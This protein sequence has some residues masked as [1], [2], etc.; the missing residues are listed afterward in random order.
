[1]NL[2]RERLNLPSIRYF[3]FGLLLLIFAAVLQHYFSYL[4][5]PER[6]HKEVERTLHEKE[7]FLSNVLET[8][9]QNP[10]FFYQDQK[11]ILNGE[12]LSS[13]LPDKGL[14]V[15]VYQKD[16]LVY[17]STNSIVLPTDQAMLKKSSPGIEK[18][19]NGY[20]AIIQ[21]ADSITKY[22]GLILIKNEYTIENE[23]IKSNFQ[24]DFP[25]PAGTEIVFDSNPG[26]IKDVKADYLFTLKL[27]EKIPP[28]NLQLIVLLILYIT[29]F[30]FFIIA[31]YRFFLG[32]SWNHQIKWLF[33]VIFIMTVILLRYLQVQF[34]FPQLLYDSALFGP[35]C[36]S[37]SFIL[38]SAGDFLINALILLVISYLLYLHFPCSFDLSKRSTILKS[39]FILVVFLVLLVG[40]GFC[41][42]VIRVLVIN[43]SIP[44]TLQKISVLNSYSLV[45]F[46]IIA[47]VFLSYLLI[48]VRLLPYF[49]ILPFLKGHHQRNV[50]FSFKVNGRSVV[51]FLFLMSA[52]A[53]LVL[54][55]YNDVVEMEKRKLLA[56]KLSTNQDPMAEMLFTM[57]EDELVKEPLFNTAESYDTRHD[58]VIS[59]DSLT[60]FVLKKYFRES[61]NNY[62][63]QITVCQQSKLL[64]IQPRNELVNCETYFKD[65]I[66]DFGKPT[67]S[68][69]LYY[70]DYGYGFRNYLAVM[71]FGIRESAQ[72]NGKKVYI[73]ISSKLSF[74]DLGYPEL[75]IDKNH[76]PV[77]D[78]ADYSY[79]F[80]RDGRLI[81]RVGSNQ[82]SL[83]LDHTLTHQDA[84]IHY[85]T[86]LGL[87]CLCYPIDRNNVLIISKKAETL[88]D[89]IAP[90]AYLFFVFGIFTFLF[91]L[92]VRRPF[93]LY[94]VRLKF[95]DRLQ[96]SMIGMLITSLIIVGFLVVYY[97]TQLNREKN[98]QS[99]SE[100]AHSML[101]E[102]Q[103]K[104]GAEE[105]LGNTG[106]DDLNELLVKFSNVFFC[107]VNLYNPG[108][109]LI[110]SSRPQVF[111]EGLISNLINNNAYAN[112]R[113]AHSSLY[114]HNETIGT[115]HYSSAYIPF[116]NDRSKLLAY[117]NLP[118]F[119]KQEEL[120]REIS[121]FLM[122]FI[123]VYVFLI[124]IGFFIAILVSN[125]IT[126][127]L[128]LLTQ[129]FVKLTL[130]SSNEKLEWHGN[131]EVGKLVQEYN[132]K[133]DELARSAEMLAQ[134]ERETAW[135]EM[136]RQIAHEIKNP[137][138]P[139]KLSV[140]YLQ[141]SW[142][143]KA[144]NWD[145]RIKRFT[146]T[147]IEQID[148]LAF[149]ASEFSAFAK[150]PDSHTERLDLISIIQN[151]VSLYKD[152]VPVI[153][154][155]Q[156]E[157]EHHFINADR[158][159]IMRVFTNLLNNS[160]QAIGEGN[161]G[162]IDIRV[163]TV[164]GNHLITLTDNGSGILPEEAGKIFQPY[165]T[166]KSGGMG[167][168]LAIVRNI[169]LTTGGDIT[170]SS[171]TGK[172]TTFTIYLPAF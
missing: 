170:F 135:R 85:Y 121:S 33:L 123:N 63:V 44:L 76:V 17:W 172:G 61:W 73:E 153:F 62:N 22:V 12:K 129:G 108:G 119:A 156:T 35:A 137:L 75:L 66:R 106:P 113:F 122:A 77:S 139:M 25:V 82:F 99:L 94:A 118:Y 109:Q 79:A 72:E 149:I 43:S 10:S 111:E 166:T 80:Y 40:F 78:L 68:P 83:D 102:M 110:A 114:I 30:L 6:I 87:S 37:S 145:Q 42:Y 167:L 91:L 16:S 1:M 46:I 152:T 32:I 105:D 29:G 45:A 148:S 161:P 130:G 24:S 128:K 163:L 41:V 88:L 117:L 70:L 52:T 3:F 103:H 4:K 141:K 140:Q 71:P 146:E 171:Q 120:K 151:A 168:G 20:Y 81:H 97:I 74:R 143:E 95:S 8:L 89:K 5:T 107:D 34:R 48:V 60:A 11:I 19:N 144:G 55:H 93:L 101:V 38:P 115:H 39:L 64:R 157:S 98:I 116:Y 169:I 9:K 112:L 159:Q 23:Y 54:N 155:I 147:M 59:D 132:R 58:Q 133:I 150:M 14:A 131:D 100:R 165:F 67:S 92:I 84:H 31:L 51:F 21:T 104:L 26:G 18:L 86:T 69:Y 127:P 96:L 138:T 126:R 50:D 7:F 154:T 2:L 65:I 27:P 160:I 90:F 49:Y 158:K 15:F 142:E 47:S 164:S 162:E 13:L 134:S 28:S 36:F 53:T 125:Y 57:L 124:I 136:A 56:V